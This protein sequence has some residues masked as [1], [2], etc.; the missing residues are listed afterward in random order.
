MS[1]AKNQNVHEVCSERSCDIQK[2]FESSKYFEPAYDRILIKREKSALE[3]KMQKSGI[4]TPDTVKESY[5]SAEGYLIKC[6]PT[7]DK[8][9]VSLIGKK[10]LFAKYGGEDI[11]V[12]LPDGEKEEFVLA[13]D[14]DIF[15]ELK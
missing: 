2:A 11:I 1:F 12:P 13:T 7:A 8:E 15:G 6:G 4:I 10:I 3:R 5:K 9:A 14:S